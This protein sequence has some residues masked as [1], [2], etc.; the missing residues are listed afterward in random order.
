[1]THER[2]YVQGRGELPRIGQGSADRPRDPPP[3]RRHTPSRTLRMATEMVMIR[4]R[5]TEVETARCPGT[6]KAT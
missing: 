4:E 6:G 3:P 2:L 1:M 5:P